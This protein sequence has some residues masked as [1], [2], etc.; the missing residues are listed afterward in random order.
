MRLNMPVFKKY[1][2]GLLSI[3]SSNARLNLLNERLPRIKK[4]SID[5]FVGENVGDGKH[6]ECTESTKTLAKKS[7]A[8]LDP[9]LSELNIAHFTM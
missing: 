9:L 7:T 6:V 4:K 3:S 2:T 8:A 5:T 1:T